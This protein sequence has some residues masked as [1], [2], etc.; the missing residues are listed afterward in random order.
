MTALAG[1]EVISTKPVHDRPTWISYAQLAFYAGFMY[2]FGATQALLRDEQGTSRSTAALH[3]TAFA[4]GAVVASLLTA[5]AIHRWGRGLVMR[6]AAITTTASI[7]LY[8]VPHAV[9][10]VTLTGSTACGTV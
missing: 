3:G 4:V 9:L 6:V 2:A 10:P 7:L 1:S 8:T 5:R